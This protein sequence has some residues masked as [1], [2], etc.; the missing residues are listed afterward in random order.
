MW[1]ILYAVVLTG[2]GFWS[3]GRDKFLAQSGGRRISENMLMLIAL[4]GGSVGSITGM[5]LFRHKTLHN[6]FRFGLPVIL[7][8]QIILLVILAV[9]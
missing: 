9:R 6:K 2:V 4:L 7:A 1:W 8:L 5:M 3:M